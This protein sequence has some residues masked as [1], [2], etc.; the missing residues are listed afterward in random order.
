[1]I[2]VGQ[3][4]LKPVNQYMFCDAFFPGQSLLKEWCKY[5]YGIFPEDGQF[6]DMLYPA[7]YKEGNISLPSQGCVE[8]NPLCPL[9][10]RYNR[11]APTKQNLLCMGQSAIETVLNHHDFQVASRMILKVE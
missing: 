10:Q 1:M 4:G 3:S 11:A 5:R 7:T 2:L 8:K 6:G 9:G